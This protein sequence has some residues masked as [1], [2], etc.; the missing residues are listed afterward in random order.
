MSAPDPEQRPGRWGVTLLVFAVA[1]V[2]R[3]YHLYELQGTAFE[4]ERGL[5]SDSRYYDMRASEIANGELVG[6]TPGFLSPT[7]CYFL[8]A[9]YAATG[10]GAFGAKVIQALLGALTVA[11][12]HRIGRRL[13]SEAAGLLAA[14]LLCAYGL[15]I[16]YSALLLPATLV[17]FLH[18]LLLWLL[19]RRPT[20]P[21]GGTA[22]AAGLVIGL[23][24][25]TKANALLLLPAVGAWLLLG[26]RERPRPERLR[27]VLLVALGALLTVAPITWRNYATSGEFVLVTTTGGRNLLKGNGEN[28]DGTHSPL[29]VESVHI[30]RYLEGRVDVA[31]A[32][33]E[34]R[35]LS[36]QAWSAMRGDPA[37]ALGLFITKL[38]LV[39]HH[40]ELGIRDSYHFMRSQ[41]SLLG[42]PLVGFGTLVPIGLV[43]LLLS[44]GRSRWTTVTS[45][46]LATQ[47]VSF[48]LIFVLGRYR[49]VAVF[50]LALFA[51][52]ALVAV[53][54]AARAR[55]WRRMALPL[56]LA[57]PAT[58][59]VHADLSHLKGFETQYPPAE[60]YRYLADWH[61]GR[62]DFDAAFE[63][64]ELALTTEW[65]VPKVYSLWEVR[66]RLGDCHLALGQPE[67]A[68][69]MWSP[70]LADIEK[71]LPERQMELKTR[72]YEKLGREHGE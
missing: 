67:L 61:F 24:I 69:E 28:A 47:V 35:E 6:T 30:A 13:F 9:T 20:G 52:Q 29:T 72:L 16:Y 2:L 51:A 22:L 54:A 60:Q 34:D 49:I 27:T 38:R 23:A 21:F 7:Y 17:C 70:L 3:L 50:C 64:Y 63:N 4:D 66:D 57:L 32:V 46:M 15:L 42:A 31:R 19:V 36:A 1:L 18:A 26:F 5:I 11:L 45:L 55:D 71:A 40:V 44:A 68:V 8:G 53:C 56:A 65:P 33:E 48:V 37:R 12:A 62:G 41:S 39:F 59:F 25:G 10:A 14:A 58:L 43:G